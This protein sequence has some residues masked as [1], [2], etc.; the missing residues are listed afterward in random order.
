MKRIFPVLVVE[1]PALQ[2]VGVN[3]YLHQKF[4][5]ARGAS[6]QTEPLMV[7][8]IDELELILP[9][10]AAGDISWSEL[11]QRRKSGAGVVAT[12]VN[13][14]FYEIASTRRLRVR[15]DPVQSAAGERLSKIVQS[16]YAGLLAKQEATT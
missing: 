1:D 2:T 6:A 8:T 12:P 5:E 16:K 11:A 9:Y 14:T 10:L 7:F 15:A 4:F 13:T 3:S